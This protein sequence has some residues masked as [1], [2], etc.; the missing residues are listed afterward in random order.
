MKYCS[1]QFKHENYFV[2]YDLNDNIIAYF[3]NFVE[4]SKIFNYRL[5]D[6]VF[7]FNKIGKNIVIVVIDNKKYKLVTFK[8]ENYEK[9]NDEKS[10]KGIKK[11]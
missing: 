4:L 1:K 9:T 10:C 3:D 5:C 7:Q 2:L 8:G 6:L 11:R